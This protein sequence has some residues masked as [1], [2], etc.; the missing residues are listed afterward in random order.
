ML[1]EHPQ[2]HNMDDLKT[3]INGK[4]QSKGESTHNLTKVC[5]ILTIHNKWN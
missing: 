3:C 1:K 2:S 4:W 5:D